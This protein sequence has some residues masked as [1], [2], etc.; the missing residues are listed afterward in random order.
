MSDTEQP[1]Q[2]TVISPEMAEIYAENERIEAEARELAESEAKATQEPETPEEP[3]P[4]Q[5]DVELR[6]AKEQLA[7]EKRQAQKKIK[8]LEAELNTRTSKPTDPS[9]VES[10]AQ[11]RAEEIVAQRLYNERCNQIALEGRKEYGEAFGEALSKLNE[12]LD[13]DVGSNPVFVEAIEETGVPAKL[14]KYL[15]DNLQEAETLLTL[16]PHRLAVKLEKLATKLTQTKIPTTAPVAPSNPLKAS[17]SRVPPP[18]KPVAGKTGGTAA[19]SKSD[20]GEELDAAAFVKAWKA[21]RG[22]T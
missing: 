15:G 21:K 4:N 11:K 5:E 1:D 22:I 8:Q 7:W 10:L 9:D 14:I 6:K 2:E 19:V 3:E 12:E 17:V 13:F 16:P 20:T 18:I